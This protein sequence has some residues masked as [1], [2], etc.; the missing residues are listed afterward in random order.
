MLL[1]QSYKVQ[2]LVRLNIL[3]MNKKIDKI[4]I[5]E[6]NTCELDCDCGWNLRI[7]GKD[8]SDLKKIKDYLKK[9]NHKS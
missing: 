3:T 8:M 4:Y 5:L 9:T 1:E 7:S 2:I 6:E